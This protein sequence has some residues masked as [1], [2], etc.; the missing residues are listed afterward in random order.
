MHRPGK[1]P[2][3]SNE[4]PKCY[5]L[6]LSFFLL[7][8]ISWPLISVNGNHNE[9]QHSRLL[10]LVRDTEASRNKRGFRNRQYQH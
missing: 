2:C 5:F 8:K 7:Y 3:N 4:F 6:S 10:H 1:L 9:G